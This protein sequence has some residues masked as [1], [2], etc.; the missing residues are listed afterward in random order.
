MTNT[1]C[2]DNLTL[3][4]EEIKQVIEGLHLPGLEDGIHRQWR[5]KASRLTQAGQAEASDPINTST[6][7]EIYRS[8]LEE[9]NWHQPINK[10]AFYQ[11]RHGKRKP[12]RPK[13]MFHQYTAKVI[14]SEHPPLPKEIRRLAQDRKQWRKIVADCLAAGWVSEWVIDGLRLTSRW[15]CWFLYRT[16]R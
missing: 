13:T 2:P 5:K 16:M 7:A 10:Y 14:N 8:H 3:N 4:N 9:T 6:S 11:P 12:G 1:N 15:P